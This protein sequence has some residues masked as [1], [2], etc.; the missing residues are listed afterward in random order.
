MVHTNRRHS[1]R[2][3]ASI[4]AMVDGILRCATWTACTGFKASTLTLLNDSFTEDSAQEYAVA[5]NGRQIESL[6]VSWMDRAR[7]M[8]LLLDLDLRGAT[9]WCAEHDMGPLVVKPHQAGTCRHCA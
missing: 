9:G 2:E 1:V 7:L 8:D 6:T 4:E 3:F 5:R